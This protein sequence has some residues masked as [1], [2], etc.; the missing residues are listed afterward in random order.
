M[1]NNYY[2]Q[3]PLGGFNQFG[4]SMYGNNFQQQQTV[5]STAMRQLLNEQQIK[6]LQQAPQQFSTKLT[7]NEYLRAICT[8]K[9]PHTGAF[10]LQE[11][12]DGRFHCTICG[13]NFRLIDP[14]TSK[15]EIDRICTNF[16]D[17]FQTIKAYYGDAPDAFK[18]YYIMC[19]FIPKTAY[20]WDIAR[21]YFERIPIGMNVQDPNN[22]YGWQLL[23]NILGGN[24]MM[25]SVAPGMGM[26][27]NMMMGGVPGYNNGYPNGMYN[28]APAYNGY[29]PNPGYP[30]NQMP[31]QN[32]VNPGYP[33]NSNFAQNPNIPVQPQ[34]Q[35][36]QPNGG[37]GMP[38]PNYVGSPYNNA[39]AY[40]APPQ[41]AANA[42]PVGYVEQP[43]QDFTTTTQKVAMPGPNLNAGTQQ[44]P[45]MPEPPKNPNIKD[46]KAT[47]SKQF[48]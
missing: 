14:S 25:N 42:N 44:N 19:G 16:N 22:Q 47:V 38:M 41:A 20:L 15:E 46:P 33:N 36:P 21:K 31:P 2:N 35:A 18:D 9:D 30:Q 40:G 32:P 26:G 28:G 37:Y 3:A 29:N 48:K 23:G 5:Q 34:P 1:S 7:H 8:H 39:P 43:Q 10:T 12:N 24:N 27:N 4:G 6:E 13:E 11:M 17:L 45:V